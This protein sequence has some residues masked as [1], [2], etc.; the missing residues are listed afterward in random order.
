MRAQVVDA[1][2]GLGFPAKQAEATV[3][4]VLG[5][6]PQNTSVVLRKSLALLGRKR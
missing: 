4:T 1:L 2:L 6:G 5:D 3:D